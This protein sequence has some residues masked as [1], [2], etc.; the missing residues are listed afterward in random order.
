MGSQTAL[1]QFSPTHNGTS[2]IFLLKGR[3]VQILFQDVGHPDLI[4]T[5]AYDTVSV[6]HSGVRLSLLLRQLVNA[7]LEPTV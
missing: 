5:S 7:S 1:L 3:V 6:E 2:L 4:P